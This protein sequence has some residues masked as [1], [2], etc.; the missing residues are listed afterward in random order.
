MIITRLIRRYFT[1]TKPNYY[2]LFGLTPGFT[3]QQLKTAYLELVKKYH[4]DLTQ[5]P[6]AKDIFRQV[7][8][9]YEVLSN[10]TARTQYQQTQE[11]P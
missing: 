6:N 8:E 5:D 3:E 4:P 7:Q 10:Q 2:A 1:Q 11:A 9:G